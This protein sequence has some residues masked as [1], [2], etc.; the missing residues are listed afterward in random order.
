MPK[1]KDLMVTNVITIDGS[2]TVAEAIEK[3]R[4]NGVR[5]L[6][7]ERRNEDDAFGIVT[8]RD[9]VYKVV[10]EGLDP[11]NTAVHEIMSKPLISLNPNL[12]AKYAARLMAKCNIS[13]APVIAE[14]R[15]MGILSLADFVK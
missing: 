7:V 9:V 12:D 15:L 3:M 10:A 8:M 1:V 13:H 5:S 2:A 11:K 4:K 14:H 6:I